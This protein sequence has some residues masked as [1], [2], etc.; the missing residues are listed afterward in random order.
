MKIRDFLDY[1]IGNNV[2]EDAELNVI[3]KSGEMEKA[4]FI[5]DGENGEKIAFYPCSFATY[6]QQKGEL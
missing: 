2:S 4:K 6:E 1:V 5:I 3:N